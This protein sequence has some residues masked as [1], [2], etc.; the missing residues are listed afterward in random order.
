[1]LS[2]LPSLQGAAQAQG[3]F[4]WPAVIA[5][6]CGFRPEHLAAVKA[7]WTAAAYWAGIAAWTAT[8]FSPPPVK[9]QQ[10]KA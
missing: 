10:T 1:M 6:L 8:P 2:V 5:G 9:E 4:V 3:I 7:S